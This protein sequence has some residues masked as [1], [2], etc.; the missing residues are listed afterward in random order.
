MQPDN[1]MGVDKKTKFETVFRMYYSQ[2]Y[3]YAGQFIADDDERKDVVSSVFEDFWCQIDAVREESVRPYLYKN[4]RNKCL[5]RLRHEKVR[6]R[7]SALC[8]SL[9]PDMVSDE[10][11]SEHLEREQLVQHVLSELPA[12]TKDIFSLCYLDGLKYK[13]AAAKLGIS[14]ASVQMHIVRA[15]KIIRR[16]NHKK[17]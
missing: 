11:V 14:T 3:C 9:T 16:R 6:E 17:E 15:L 7:Y 8:R 4:T 5:D 10:S 12:P 2:L 13:E 1:D